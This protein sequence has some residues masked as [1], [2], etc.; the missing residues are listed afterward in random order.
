MRKLGHSYGPIANCSLR[1]REGEGRRQVVGR[2]P[3]P[4]Q[5]APRARGDEGEEKAAGGDGTHRP[6]ACGRARWNLFASMVA[7]THVVPMV[8]SSRK[9]APKSYE[10]HR[11]WSSISGGIM[12][13]S[14]AFID[15]SLATSKSTWPEW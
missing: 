4:A 14:A 3:G 6:S 12:L 2:G 7:S 15:G 13:R 10:M 1:E 11:T 9:S 8:S 5:G